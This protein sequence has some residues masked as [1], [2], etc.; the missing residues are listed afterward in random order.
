MHL[1]VCR[2]AINEEAQTHAGAE[3][4]H[5]QE[6]ILW[7]GLVD[8]VGLHAR[9]LDPGIQVAENDHT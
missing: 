2:P 9:G 7:L 6:A 1:V 5:E 4:D 8:V 3:P